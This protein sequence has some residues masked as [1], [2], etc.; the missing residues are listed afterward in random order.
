MKTNLE[1]VAFIIPRSTGE[2]IVKIRYPS[3]N[4]DRSCCG[5]CSTGK[6]KKLAVR[7]ASA[8][9]AGFAVTDQKICVDV[10][11]N[12][13]VSDRHQFLGRTLNASLK[14]LGF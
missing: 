14:R 12:T 9:N 11:G 7:L 6:N 5:G 13:Y 4:V 1:P 10:N 2:F 3:A 8:I